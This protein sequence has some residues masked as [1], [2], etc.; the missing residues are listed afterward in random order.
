MGSK[1]DFRPGPATPDLNQTRAGLRLLK[2]WDQCAV[3]WDRL[4]RVPSES[5]NATNLRAA[6][7][8]L[9]LEL[10]EVTELLLSK[11]TGKTTELNIQS[12][13]L[14]SDDSKRLYVLQ[15]YYYD[16]KTLS[17]I[18]LSVITDQ[19]VLASEVKESNLKFADP[20][21]L[22]LVKGPNFTEA[23]YSLHSMLRMLQDDRSD[24]LS[25]LAKHIETLKENTLTHWSEKFTPEKTLLVMIFITWQVRLREIDAVDD[26][27][28][29]HL[30]PI[31]DKLPISRGFQTEARLAVV[32]KSAGRF[33]APSS[34]R[35]HCS[36]PDL[37]LAT[38]RGDQGRYPLET[39][40]E[41]VG[42]G[43]ASTSFQ[44]G[45]IPIE[46][47]G[48]KTVKIRGELVGWEE[49]CDVRLVDGKPAEP[50]TLPQLGMPQWHQ[51]EMDK[52]VK[53]DR[54]RVVISV[55]GSRL[56]SLD[57]SAAGLT[58][59]LEAKLK[60]RAEV[61]VAAPAYG[62]APPEGDKDRRIWVLATKH[63]DHAEALR[64]WLSRKEQCHVFDAH[65]AGFL[66]KRFPGLAMENE[67]VELLEE[68][69]R[70]ISEV[71]AVEKI[72]SNLAF[73]LQRHGHWQLSVSVVEDAR[74]ASPV[75][76]LVKRRI[77]ELDEFPKAVLFAVL[78]AVQRHRDGESVN[79][80]V[81]VG[82]IARGLETLDSDLENEL[83]Y[84]CLEE[85]LL[86]RDRR[87][88]LYGFPNIVYRV[89]A[90]EVEEERG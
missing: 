48:G 63:L 11:R 74:K 83:E 13:D 2:A 14:K 7:Q 12:G 32:A 87:G 43:V 45:H 68:Y 85:G 88:V 35:L 58:E 50:G 90:Q 34:L 8:H 17:A 47:E 52:L 79:P 54:R 57:L 37:P 67:A 26:Y 5:L 29:L 4:N 6:A 84:L 20:E 27:K 49:A 25:N 60:D 1:G 61:V 70:P 22:R 86:E 75:T 80:T 46:A 65:L 19:T 55:E 30:A 64:Y 71:P 18:K 72:L 38:N 41:S 76:D 77:R 3:W 44:V 16:I 21:I 42:P 40:V 59:V 51:Q 15:R 73:M 39:S 78:D 28:A 89:A 56:Q 81:N 9:S 10:I 31:T 23:M 66:R 62:V 24:F 53:S 69:I 82:A 33:T 36:P